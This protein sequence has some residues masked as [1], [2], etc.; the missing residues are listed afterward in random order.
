MTA[1][2]LALYAE[3]LGKEYQLGERRFA[4]ESLYE[5]LAGWLPGAR[6]PADGEVETRGSFWALRDVSFEVARGEVIGI[7]GRNGAGK[8]TLLKIL[9]RITAPTEGRAV[10]H[11]KLASLLEVG[12]G[13][14]PE[15]TGRENI[16]LN[17][18]ILGM[19]RREIAR[20][21][22]DI[23]AFAEVERF[24]DT[25]VKR[26]SSGMYVRL[27]FAVAAHLEADVLVV[28]EVLAVG[29]LAF[30]RKWLG[31]MEDVARSGR[32][33][34]FVSH[35]LGAVRTLCSSVLLLEGG[36]VAYRGPTEEGLARYEA[37]L[38]DAGAVIASTRFAGPLADRVRFHSFAL[39]QS[40][41]EVAVIDP[42]LPVEVLIAGEAAA[43]LGTLELNL[44]LEPRRRAALLLSRRAAGDAAAA[45]SV[46]VALR[47][48]RRRAAARPL[49][50][51]RR[52]LPAGGRR[53][54][55]VPRRRG[56]R[57]VGALERARAVARRGPRHRAVQRR[58]H[59]MNDVFHR[60]SR[61]LLPRRYHRS[62]R[63]QA[64]LATHVDGKVLGGPFAGMRYVDRSF[65]SAYWPKVLGTYELELATRVEGLLRRPFRT[66]L[67]AGAAEGYYAIG[68][69]V[70]LAA[71][72]VVAWEASEPA[73]AAMGELAALN[74][75]EE[76]IES[77]AICDFGGL[78]D[79]LAG[80]GPRLL[81][82]DLDGGEAALLDPRALPAL[83][84][85]WIVAE[86]H[87]CFVPGVAAL[88]AERFAATHVVEA[89]AARPR[90]AADA[91]ALDLPKSFRGALAQLLS[92][93]RPSGNDWLVMTPAERGLKREVT[94]GIGGF[95]GHDANAALVV[96]DEIVAAAQEERYT[97]RKHDGSFP[98]RAIADCLT[99]GG[100]RAD[101]RLYRR[102]RR[103]AFAVAL[104]RPHRQERLAAVAAARPRA[105]GALGSR[106][107]RAGAGALPS[108]PHPLRLAPPVARRRRLL[109]LR[110]RVGRLP[111]HRRQG[112]GLQRQHRP[113]RRRAA[114]DRRR[115]AVGGGARPL[116][117]AGHASPR[118]PTFG[119]EYKVMGLAPYGVPRFVDRL[120]SI[121]ATDDRG[122]V[123]LLAP[124]RFVSP[125]MEAGIAVV[126][127]ATGVPRRK[128]GD[129]VGDE[130]ADLAASLQQIFE[131]EVFKQA[132]HVRALTGERQLLFTGGCAQNCVAAGKLRSH[133]PFEEVHNSPVAGDMGSGL[134]AAL[135]HQRALG[136]L[137]GAKADPRG[138]YLGPEPGEPP[139]AALPFEETV[140]GDL[141]AHVAAELAAGKIVAWC[142]D[143]MEL[144]ARALGARSI[145]ADA[146]TAE[147]AVAA[148]P[149]RQVPRGLPPVRAHRAR[150]ESRRVVRLG[151]AEPLH[152]VRRQP[153]RRAP[154]A[155]AG[156]RPRHARAPRR[157]AQRDRQRRARRLLGAAANR[158]ARHPPWL[159]RPPHRVRREDRR[160][161]PHQHQLQ[162]RRAADRAHG[163]GSLGVL[164][165]H[166]RRSAGARRPAVPPPRQPDARREDRMG[167]RLYLLLLS[168]YRLVAPR[169]RAAGWVASGRRNE[170]DSR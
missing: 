140:R 75:V 17:G 158:R 49:L 143:R 7:V 11:G 81:V 51:R 48:R 116:L 26:Y 153:S 148:Q 151:A 55:L 41:E 83:A 31:K 29:D 79:A 120:R 121:L 4:G 157:A 100:L 23:V 66:V 20:K 19:R 53:L 115:A 136:I 88:L 170:L 127:R 167:T 118:L 22:D 62:T 98:H 54:D 138:Y 24:L 168:L 6:R 52:R 132:E 69:A 86:T 64:L 139:A 131:E 34:L 27:A 13:F 85:T 36:R 47:A 43:D 126:E 72:R 63:L 14:H 45:G 101:G 1:G 102:L 145:L 68:L 155:D 35:N 149:R 74:G 59:A 28:D 87:D 128:S 146:R 156:R 39:R 135:L 2:E 133:G 169:R 114:G 37:S 142:R 137:D 56:R 96:D 25:P 122:A 108:R 166:R 76:R 30:Q 160:P 113:H 150:G 163:R 161:H 38:A 77:R 40:G 103:E 152:A 109:H 44:G 164:R 165:P 42:T 144:G 134:G 50:D 89:V 159:P 105:T 46:S 3:G 57:S 10:L 67:V 65:G 9:S 147:H 82:A 61:A 21:F 15:L 60:A 130:H 94:L 8:S 110:V 97:R 119:S 84:D 123:R 112:R 91:P 93:R 154:A 12:T 32:T 99:I 117:H 5:T 162:R 124:V 70:R 71:A 90:S 125:E 107:P 80:E 129:P 141:F 95:L 18:T 33:V 106:L 78:A 58:A 16:Y 73:R 111:L 104:L 92:E